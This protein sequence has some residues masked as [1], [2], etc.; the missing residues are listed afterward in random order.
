MSDC[1]T[2]L[3]KFL[4][5]KRRTVSVNFSGGEVSSDGGIVLLREVDRKLG[6]TAKAAKCFEDKR[7]RAKIQHT[8][9]AMVRQRVHGIALGYADLNDHSTLR[10]DTLMQLTAGVDKPLASAPTLCRLENTANQQLAIDLHKVLIEQFI[11]SFK[12]APKELILDFDATDDPV[13]GDQVGKFFHGYYD[14]HCFLPLY[15]F[16]GKQLLVSYLR[17]AKRDA[18]THSWAILALL[19]KR[20]RQVWPGVT[21]IFRGDGGFCRHEMFNW[22]ERNNVSYITGMTG[23]NILKTKLAPTMKEAAETYALT[24]E[25]QRIFNEFHY[26]AKT[27]KKER[28]V[29]GKAEHAADGANPRFIITNITG[30]PA[31]TLYEEIYCARG[32]MENRLKEQ[33]NL[34]SDRTSCHEWWPNQLRVLLAS[35]AYTLIQ[36]LRKEALEG[37]DLAAAQTDTI[38]LKLFKIGAI[39]IRNTRKVLLKMSSHYPNQ[40]LFFLAA[41]R[42]SLA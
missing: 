18:S 29:I 38:R 3:F 8:I 6:L 26:Q 37:T 42:L 4:P 11:A 28:R 13:H 15:V 35:L 19:V 1:T 2:G 32:E 10:H 14:H 30:N 9:E 27:W 22:C 16:C 24:G 40:E 41:K 25:K 17:T 34:F 12:E 7:N 39:V 36:H 31:Q 5:E 20:F 33:F 21:I 23:N